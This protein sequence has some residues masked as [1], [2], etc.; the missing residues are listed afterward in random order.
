M[1]KL[2]A[3]AVAT[4]LIALAPAAN[5]TVVWT[6][7]E[8]SCTG[9]SFS[10]PCHSDHPV[11]FPFPLVTL[12]LPGPTSAGTAVWKPGTGPPPPVY[13]GDTFVLSYPGIL[14]TPAF[15]GSNVVGQCSAPSH[16]ICNFDLSWSETA[17]QLGSVSIQVLGTNDQIG[18]ATGGGGFGLTG[19]IF[20][21]D[22]EVDNCQFAQCIATGFWQSNLPEPVSASLLLSGLLGLGFARRFLRPSAAEDRL[23]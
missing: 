15:T 6:F 8:T 5:A 17:G 13:T 22:G 16:G 4:V 20:G 23:T 7:F 10:G 11:A 1:N 21:S 12:T 9:F 19:G 14:L 2:I 3:L 18:P